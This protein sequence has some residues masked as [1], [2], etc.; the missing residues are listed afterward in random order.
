VNNSDAEA[1][2]FLEQLEREVRELTGLRELE[3]WY[4]RRHHEVWEPFHREMLRLQH[5]EGVDTS[6]PELRDRVA[7]DL[8]VATKSGQLQTL[9]QKAVGEFV[10]R[11]AEELLN[12]DSEASRDVV[13]KFDAAW[14]ELAN[15]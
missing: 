15:R 7:R 2:A 11:S 5:K 14:R 3:N 6:V 12:P 13:E 8:G 1:R 9:Y 4:L 10:G